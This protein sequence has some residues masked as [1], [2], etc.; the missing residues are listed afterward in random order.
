MVFILIGSNSAFDGLMDILPVSD[1]NEISTLQE[2][3]K[4]RTLHAWY[5]VVLNHTFGVT[6]GDMGLGVAFA[7][8]VLYSGWLASLRKRLSGWKKENHRV[9]PCFLASAVLRLAAAVGFLLHF[10]TS[11]LLL[12]CY[13]DSIP[14]KSNQIH[15]PSRPLGTARLSQYGLGPVSNPTQSPN[16]LILGGPVISRNEPIV[17]GGGFNY[18]KKPYCLA[19]MPP[20]KPNRMQMLFHNT[21]DTY[22][23]SQNPM[24]ESPPSA[25]NGPLH[26]VLEIKQLQCTT[27][28]K[29]RT[30]ALG[31]LH[32]VTILAWWMLSTQGG[33]KSPAIEGNFP[34]NKVMDTDWRLFIRW[35]FLIPISPVG[36][37]LVESFDYCQIFPSSSG[38]RPGRGLLAASVGEWPNLPG[39]W[40]YW[41]VPF[42]RSRG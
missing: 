16:D 6:G 1:W 41:G 39:V 2:S 12:S 3:A 11:H 31:C 4:R 29:S 25:G 37:I 5:W 27:R 40:A 32:S 13:L 14:I 28:G 33:K 21:D 9:L 36:R 17:Q 30:P 34:L 19:R 8:T 26:S 20:S 22:S 15:L 38:I 42:H 18:N 7:A 24:I 35:S 23:S 10:P